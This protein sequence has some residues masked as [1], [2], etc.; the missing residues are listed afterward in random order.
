MSYYVGIDLGGTNIAV[1]VVDENRQIVGRAN[2]KTKAFHPAEEIADDMAATARRAV[3]NAGVTFDE[4]AWVGVGTPGTVNP[5]TGMVGLAANLGFHDTPLG[6]LVAE[7]L[8][9]KVYVEND[10]N[11]AAY[12][13]L[14]AGAAEGLD[15][16]VLIT[17]GTGVGGGIVIDGKIQSGF[18]YKGAELGHIGMV[19]Q[20]VPCTCGRRGCIESYCAVTGLIRITRESMQ[21]NAKSKM[22]ELAEGSLDKVSGRTAFDAMRA[23]DEAGKAVVDQYIDYLA[24][25][26]SGIINLFQPQAVVIGGGISKEGETLFGPMRERAYPQTFNYDPNN[27]SQI[28]KAK[29]GNDA[30]IIG[31]ALL[32]KQYK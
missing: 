18:N 23:G 27:C 19:Y 26:V 30:G 8:G 14:M 6:M 22:W 11:A 24:Y 4:V 20:G 1:G 10:A 16:V 29:L 9:K 21:L 32:G 17:L 7:R 12:G 31:A 3:E 2:E 25:A 28:I 5:E 13:E 15:S